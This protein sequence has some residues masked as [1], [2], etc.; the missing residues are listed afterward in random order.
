MDP[1]LL[2]GHDPSE[3]FGVALTALAATGVPVEEQRAGT[4]DALPTIQEISGLIMFGGAMNVDM[5]DAHPYLA[6]ERRFVREVV[7]NGIPFLGIC[8]GAQ[9]LARAHD[10]RVFPAGIREFGFNPLRPTPE[11]TD[12]LLLSAFTDGDMV[13][14]WHED[15][16]QLPNGSVL[17]ARG[18]DVPMQA[19]RIG[20]HAWGLQFHIEV[21]RPE[22]DLWLKSAGAH[23]VRSWG[24]TTEQVVEE[25]DLY[26]AAQEGKAREVFRRFANVVRDST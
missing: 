15:T 9:M 5:T 14:H 12:D 25:L 11:A 7:A 6:E 20:E 19:F 26:L 23:G 21:D 13:F 8:L 1:V 22:V 2:I 24:K 3:T 10:G 17:L 16:F 4:D 18:D